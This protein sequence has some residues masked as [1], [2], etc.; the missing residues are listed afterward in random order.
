MSFAL[1]AGPDHVE[2]YH[3]A[4]RV[5]AIASVL[6]PDDGDRAVRYLA[7]AIDLGYD[8]NALALEESFAP[9]RPRQ[10]FKQLLAGPANPLAMPPTRRIVDPGRD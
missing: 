5:F 6:F 7:A 2:L 4:A 8:P 9:L 3:D 1:G 10:D